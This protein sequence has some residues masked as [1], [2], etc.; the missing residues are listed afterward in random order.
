MAMLDDFLKVLNSKPVVHFLKGSI[1]AL[2]C[3]DYPF[4]T[5]VAVNYTGSSLINVKFYVTAFKKVDFS[6]VG[7]FFPFSEAVSDAYE[8]YKESKVY[9]PENMGFVFVFKVS[10]SGRM[11]YTYGQ[12]ISDDI[13]PPIDQPG[14]IAEPK[15]FDDYFA[16]EVGAELSYE[17]HY[18]IILNR[19]NIRTMLRRAA[20]ELDDADVDLLEYSTFEGKQKILAA[21]R[22]VATTEAYLQETGTPEFLE[23]HDFILSKFGFIPVS[24]GKYLNSQVRTIH[25][26]SPGEPVYF[27]DSLALMSLL[28]MVE[29]G[30]VSLEE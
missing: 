21:M 23:L 13:N 6:L 2:Y 8:K 12:R 20:M 7:R 19:E 30:C 28:E 11:L 17:K 29:K 24:P 15:R 1:D 4:C 27:R 16:H 14:L 22:S 10:P 3:P 18:Y 5:Y 26:F 9:S 25:Y